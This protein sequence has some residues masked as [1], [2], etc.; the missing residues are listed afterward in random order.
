[1][2]IVTARNRGHMYTAFIAADGRQILNIAD[3]VD[4]R[5]Q[6]V[7]IEIPVADEDLV[8]REDCAT[9]TRLLTNGLRLVTAMQTPAFAIP[10]MPRDLSRAA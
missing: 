8:A 1:M 4:G 7:S 2:S 10:V 3:I 9:I 6:C 5:L